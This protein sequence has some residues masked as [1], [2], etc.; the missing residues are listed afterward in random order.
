MSKL[1]VFIS[2][3]C[4][5]E[6]E[7]FLIIRRAIADELKKTSFVDYVYVFEDET[8]SSDDLREEIVIALNESDVVLFLIDSRLGI[9]NGV[10]REWEYTKFIDSKVLCIFYNEPRKNKTHIQLECEKLNIMRKRIDNVADF[11]SEGSKAIV[12]D[13]ISVYKKSKNQLLH[14]NQVMQYSSV[15]SEYSTFSNDITEIVSSS[16]AVDDEPKKCESDYSSKTNSDLSLMK[17]DIDFYSALYPEVG[18]YINYRLGWTAEQDKDKELSANESLVVNLF[19]VSVSLMS[20]DDLDENELNNFLKGIHNEEQVSFFVRRWD[21]ISEYYRGNIYEA[22]TILKDINDDIDKFNLPN[23]LVQ[24]ILIDL[25][26]VEQEYLGTQNKMNFNSD[27]QKKLS[28]DCNFLVYPAGDRLSKDVY[29]KLAIEYQKTYFQSPDT[30]VMGISINIPIQHYIQELITATIYGS[31]IHFNLSLTI[32]KDI[33]VNYLLNYDIGKLKIPAMKLCLLTK[34]FKMFKN[35]CDKN[36]GLLNVASVKEIDDIFNCSVKGK[37]NNFE[38]QLKLLTNLGFYISDDLFEESYKN[39]RKLILEW[40][41]DNKKEIKYG[42]LIYDMYQ[43]IGLRLDANEVIYIVQQTYDKGILYFLDDSLKILNY[44]NYS[45]SEK[46]FKCNLSSLLKS[47]NNDAEFV[48]KS[49]R[50]KNI[51]MNLLLSFPEVQELLSEEIIKWNNF[52]DELMHEKDAF[53]NASNM[54]KNTLLDANNRISNQGVNGTY[55][56]YASSPFYRINRVMNDFNNDQWS[57]KSIEQLVGVITR[58]V[59]NRNQSIGEKIEAI[60]FMMRL[61]SKFVRGLKKDAIVVSIKEIITSKE[62]I[63]NTRDE[64][65][66]NSNLNDIQ[67]NVLLLEVLISHNDYDKKLLEVYK[68]FFINDFSDSKII[69]ALGVFYECYPPK[70]SITSVS[71]LLQIVLS[72]INH[73]QINVR[74]QAINLLLKFESDEY[75]EVIE[76]I[77]LEIFDDND[78]RIKIKVLKMSNKLSMGLR[79]VLINKARLSNHF[80]VKEYIIDLENL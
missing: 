66:T 14:D 51:T 45:R 38:F 73:E 47:L 8:A 29:K 48:K 5:E 44:A 49:S 58:F 74:L 21:A 60:H 61:H 23:W 1:R 55:L 64:F 30:V 9:S 4:G 40:M 43:G 18:K 6:D 75:K 54:I 24:D 10:L 36:Q 76:S 22:F 34:D 32:L 13:I 42:S 19:K 79:T 77:I 52:S 69:T 28:D 39:I 59:L 3:S 15:S 2:S 68:Y 12:N 72:F 20:I 33:V 63:N 37:R 17:S 57:V 62:E 78:A 71:N 31:L 80:L 25:R 11:I 56:G 67:F 16:A 7:S 26:N 50:L 70:L 53:G 27:Y 65:F 41:S 46:S 35:L